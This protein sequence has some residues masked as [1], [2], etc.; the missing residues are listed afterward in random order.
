MNILKKK[1]TLI[2]YVFPKLYTGGDVV[3]KH[4]RSPISELTRMVN[5]LKGSKHCWNLRDSHFFLLA[6]T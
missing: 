6:G 1:M 3:R 2:A 5:I 4:L